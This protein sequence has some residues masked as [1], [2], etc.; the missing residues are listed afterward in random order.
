MLALI[1]E[2][3][4]TLVDVACTEETRATAQ[5]IRKYPSKGERSTNQFI[6][7][8][9][10]E[11]TAIEEGVDIRGIL[12]I[13]FDAFHCWNVHIGLSCI[14]NAQYLQQYRIIER[15][16]EVINSISTLGMKAL[17]QVLAPL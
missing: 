4:D 14:L 8:L 7:F 15:H 11:A 10:P 9:K 16:Y 1:E 6:V 13:V 3:S 12:R 5:W 2:I 17:W